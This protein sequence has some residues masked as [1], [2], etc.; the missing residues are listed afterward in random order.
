MRFAAV[1]DESCGVN[2]ENNKLY[3]CF[4]SYLCA[5]VNMPDTILKPL[6]IAHQ[7]GSCFAHVLANLPANFWP[8]WSTHSLAI[9][10]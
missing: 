5:M 10:P 2:V 3:K 7:P 4:N 6:I 1:N 9:N 8:A